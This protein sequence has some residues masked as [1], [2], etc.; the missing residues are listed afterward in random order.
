[1]GRIQMAIDGVIFVAAFLTLDAR[2]VGW[3]ALGAVVVNAVLIWNHRPGRYQVAL[4][5]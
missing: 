4:E 5:A 3:S 2:R 1:V